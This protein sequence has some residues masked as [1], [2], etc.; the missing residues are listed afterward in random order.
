MPISYIGADVDCKM[1]EL[2]VEENQKIIYRTRVKTTIP[3]LRKELSKF[4][5]KKFF[6][7]E[8]C[9]LAS[10]LYRNL[11]GHATDVI[12]SDPAA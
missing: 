9:S 5:G 12:V 6:I 3:I 7:F 8:E 4:G 1:T 2:A 10:W 11:H